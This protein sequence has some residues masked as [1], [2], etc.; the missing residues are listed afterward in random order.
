MRLRLVNLVSDSNLTQLYWMGAPVS[1]RTLE[2][3]EDSGYQSRESGRSTA[4]LYAVDLGTLDSENLWLTT[5]GEYTLF[6]VGDIGN[7]SAKLV[8]IDDDTRP[9][10]DAVKVR[11]F[12]GSPSA[13]PLDVYFTAPGVD[14]ADVAPNYKAVSYQSATNYVWMAPGTYRVRLTTPGTKDVIIDTGS[15]EGTAGQVFTVCAIGDPGV[16]QNVRSLTL[17]DR[18]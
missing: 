4:D 13:G 15:L 18:R 8:K 16:G 7:G 17:T 12:H 1:P 9:A 10:V 5:D 14:L 2:F 6:G 3:R 11:F